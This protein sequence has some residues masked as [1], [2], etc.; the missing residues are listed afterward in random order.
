MTDD[1]AKIPAQ[2]PPENSGAE[3]SAAA[4]A[5]RTRGERLFDW[6]AYGGFAGA[7]TFVLGM[8]LGYW[9]RYSNSGRQTVKWAARHL[10]NIGLSEAA[11]EDVVMTTA[12]MQGGNA[13][14][15]PVKIMEDHKP[16]LVGR[17]NKHLG[18]DTED[19]SVEDSIRQSWK[20]LLKSRLAAWLMVFGSFRTFAAMP[21]GGKKLNAFE[22]AF[23]EQ[24]FCKPLGK[25][26][27]V[28]GKETLIY[29]TGRIAALDVFATAAAAT[30]LYIGSRF[31]ARKDNDKRPAEVLHEAIPAVALADDAVEADAQKHAKQEHCARC[32]Y[33]KPRG[34]Y[35]EM[36][37]SGNTG[38][39]QQMLPQP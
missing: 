35:V 32:K 28:N 27:H 17:L 30:L 39:D 16:K 4:A 10:K 18:D 25:P 24:I 36:V 3:N 23:S 13:T 22:E 33:I 19:L 29:K 26:T 9:V 8:P 21:G 7:V 14:L 6:L 11:S 38:P 15:I 1:P 5:R 31:F 12:L 34:S 37:S 2:S 20:S